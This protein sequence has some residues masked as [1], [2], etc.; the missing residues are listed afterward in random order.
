M[1]NQPGIPL[2]EEVGVIYMLVGIISSLV[3][4]RRDTPASSIPG[5]TEQ[6]TIS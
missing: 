6:T 4:L 1:Y 5:H 2:P 3:W